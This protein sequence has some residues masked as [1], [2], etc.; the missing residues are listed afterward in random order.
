MLSLENLR[1]YVMEK[2]DVFYTK[3]FHL[4]DKNFIVSE[5][6]FEKLIIHNKESELDLF[7]VSECIGFSEYKKESEY[8]RLENIVKNENGTFESYEF[9]INTWSDQIAH[10]KKDILNKIKLYGPINKTCEASVR[11]YVS[12]ML[13]L[14]ALIAEDIMMRA[15]QKVSGLRGNG[16]VDYLFLYKKFPVIMTEV[17]DEEIGRGVAQN[18]AQ[19]VAGRQEYKYNLQ[20]HL[21]DLKENSKKRKYLEIDI[22]SIP[23]FGIVS[24]GLLWMFQKLVEEGNQ[25]IIYQSKVFTINLINSDEMQI[26]EEMLEVV[27]HIVFILKNQKEAVDGHNIAKRVNNQFPQ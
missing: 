16:P 24:S 13:S 26:E 9:D 14:A 4:K 8:L 11:E 5:D 27:R 15:E 21:P 23:S 12:P 20:D 19:L 17:K 10:A 22:T 25:T 7:V 6:N 3:E 18:D 2:W 1:L